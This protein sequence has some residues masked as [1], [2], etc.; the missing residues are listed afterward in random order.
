MDS[1]RTL[2][3]AVDGLDE[4]D[5]ADC[6]RSGEGTRSPLAALAAAASPLRIRPGGPSEPAPALTTLVTGIILFDYLTYACKCKS[7]C[8]RGSN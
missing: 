8:A 7:F 1:G 6:A 4:Q 3:I 2:M 5:L